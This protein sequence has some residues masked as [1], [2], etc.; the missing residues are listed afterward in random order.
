MNRLAEGLRHEYQSILTSAINYLPAI[1][2]VIVILLVAVV[3]IRVATA[4]LRRSLALGKLD[5][6]MVGLTTS[7]ARFLLWV[8]VIAAVMKTLGFNEVSV[9]V[10]G[11]TALIAMAL[12]SGAS[13][14]TTDILA[15][16]F[17]VS[18]PD[19]KVGKRVIAGGVEGVVREVNIRKTRIMDDAG[20]LHVLPNRS[21]DTATYVIQR[22]EPPGPEAGGA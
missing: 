7:A 11:T 1:A 2:K 12:A 19:F 4:L 13:G 16:M 15:G 5:Q 21:V 20:N 9:A 8:M 18:D 22:Y 14:T 6:T 17:L 10:A 3:L